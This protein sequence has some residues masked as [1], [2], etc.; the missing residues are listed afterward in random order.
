MTLYQQ[1]M[2]RK[3]GRLDCAGRYDEEKGLLVISSGGTG[4]RLIN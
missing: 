2:L 4:L 1:E 3:L